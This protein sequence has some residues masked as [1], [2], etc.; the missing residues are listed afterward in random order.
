M[1]SFLDL[2]TD[3]LGLFGSNSLDHGPCNPLAA[4]QQIGT[5]SWAAARGTQLT[6]QEAERPAD[7]TDSNGVRSHDLELANDATAFTLWLSAT[8]TASRYRF[9][10]L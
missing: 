2:S 1:L 6:E 9:L 7:A 5:A 10:F 8:E 3:R 4:V